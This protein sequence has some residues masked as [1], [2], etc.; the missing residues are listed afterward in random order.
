MLNNIAGDEFSLASFSTSNAVKFSWTLVALKDPRTEE[1][2]FKHPNHPNTHHRLNLRDG[3]E[4]DP[5]PLA[6]LYSPY[7]SYDIVCEI[8][9]HAAHVMNI[10]EP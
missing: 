4:T 7:S 6:S 5:L 9:P 2:D 1:P 3:V 10:D 8:S